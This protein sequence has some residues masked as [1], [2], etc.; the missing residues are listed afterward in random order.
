M[1]RE[2]ARG[3]LLRGFG[4]QI[5]YK[6]FVTKSVLKTKG[7]DNNNTILHFYIKEKIPSK[8]KLQSLLFLI[9][10][11]AKPFVTKKRE[12]PGNKGFSLFLFL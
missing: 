11:Y 12:T 7:E 1:Y 6:Y 10:Q 4:K 8:S 5:D 2:R 9:L 3:N